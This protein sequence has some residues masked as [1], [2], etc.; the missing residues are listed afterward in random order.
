[1]SKTYRRM[2]DSDQQ[3][4]IKYVSD[5]AESKGEVLSWKLLE[6]KFGFTRQAMQ[7]KPRVKF[8]FQN[9]KEAIRNEGKVS[10]RIGALSHEELIKKVEVLEGYVKLLE[11]REA[12]WKQRWQRIAYNLRKKGLQVVEVDSSPE[13]GAELPNHQEADK[14][15]R[16]YDDEDIPPPLS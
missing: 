15:L 1:M 16:L 4:I 6:K 12:K 11:E 2:S 9:A 8:A 3:A 5:L 14:I 10:R 13:R 7:A